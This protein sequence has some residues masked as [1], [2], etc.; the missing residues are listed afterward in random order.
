MQRHNIE[1][2]VYPVEQPHV[3]MQQS[4]ACD[5]SGTALQ[6]ALLHRVHSFL[7]AGGHCGVAVSVCT[8]S[9]LWFF[10]NL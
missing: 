9:F 4:S 7:V 2:R 6:S 3:Q 10:S 8:A 1:Q 5:L